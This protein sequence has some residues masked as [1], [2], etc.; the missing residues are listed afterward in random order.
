MPWLCFSWVQRYVA[1]H[2]S[3]KHGLVCCGPQC[4]ITLR[5]LER[6][7]DT[8]PRFR[9]HFIP[10][11]RRGWI[12]VVS[13]LVLFAFTQPPLVYL[14]GNRIEPRILGFPFL[15]A[16]LAVL[17]FALIGVLIWSQMKGR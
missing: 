15:Y 4:C 14:I 2:W 12:S 8:P 17:Y 3:T 6:M 16:Y 5:D 1:L 10:R 9:S 7:P 11:T 13:F